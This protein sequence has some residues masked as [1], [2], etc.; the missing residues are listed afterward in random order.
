MQV[1]FPASSYCKQSVMKIVMQ[2]S[3]WYNGAS[4]G[5]MPGSG[6]IGLLGR[7]MKG[8]LKDSLESQ[9]C[10][11]VFCWGKHVKDHSLK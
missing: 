3:L 6:I 2:L 10:W 8:K 4:F 1:F 11:M 5:Y 7:T 9:L